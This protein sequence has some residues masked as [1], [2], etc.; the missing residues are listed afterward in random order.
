MQMCIRDRY[1]SAIVPTIRFPSKL[2]DNSLCNNADPISFDPF[3]CLHSV[4]VYQNVLLFKKESL[5]E[6]WNTVK[7]QIIQIKLPA[8]NSMLGQVILAKAGYSHK[9]KQ[10]FIMLA[11]VSLT[12]S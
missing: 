9:K 4:Q 2:A 11:S 6:S 10:E 3:L 12:I 5:D 1:P 7:L 8:C